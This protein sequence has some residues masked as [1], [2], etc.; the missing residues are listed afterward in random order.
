M[1]SVPLW[2]ANEIAQATGGRWL[3]APPDNWDPRRVSYDVTGNMAGHFCVLAHP[4][5]WG[6]G[7]RDPTG[8]IPRLARQNAAGIMIERGHLDLIR[9]QH[10]ALPQDLPCLMVNS[11]WRGLQNLA[12][13]ARMRFQG[14]VFAVTGT[15]GKTT[16]REMIRHLTNLQGGATASAANNNNISGV[17]RS[18]AYMPRGNA[19]GVIEMGFGK[20][21]DG[22]A[23]SSRVAQPNVAILT[24]I[25]VAHFDMFTP[26]MLENAS[27]RQLVLSYKANVFAGLV[28]GGAAVI[29]ADM[30]EYALARAFAER[31]TDRIY[32]FGAAQHADAGIETAKFEISGTSA[33]VH[34]LGEPY[35][36]VLQVPGRHM[37]MNAL[38]ALLAV[39][40]AGFDLERAVSDIAHFK[41]VKGR[42]RVIT[43]P[44]TRGGKATIIDDSF[45]AT[46]ASVRSSIDLLG[47]ARPKTGGRRIAVLGE[48]GHIGANEADEH[49]KLADSLCRSETDLVFTWGPLMRPMFESLPPDIR[50]AHEDVS[51]EALYRELSV[52]L[53]D[54][55]VLT[56]KSGRG[57]NGLG[58]IRFRKFVEHLVAGKDELVL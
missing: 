21:L 7:R 54:G 38:A 35:D 5:S 15:V 41:P 8:D 11:T 40:V 52:R 57:V 3:I 2:T 29:N 43:A 34:I 32:S 13:I 50:G 27:G 42:A 24:T 44:L 17:N 48:I 47:L 22:I 23:R 14:K 58:D 18:L 56:L 45:N 39:V 49:R 28:P 46:L 36:L 55:D 51:V 9:A 33:R 4:D 6:K 53:R 10:G 1:N 26:E 19:A 12:Q 16:T 37:L 20:P 25:D 31:W 30:P